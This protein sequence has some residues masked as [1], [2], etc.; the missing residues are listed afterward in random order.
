MLTPSQA[1]QD[2]VEQE[3]EPVIIGMLSCFLGELF[4]EGCITRFGGKQAI[5]EGLIGL[6]DL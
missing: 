1:G 3:L 5:G 2:P 4:R 6:L